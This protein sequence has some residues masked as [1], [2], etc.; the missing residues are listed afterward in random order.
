M[1]KR[2]RK[3]LAVMLTVLMLFSTA[4]VSISS[5]AMGRAPEED[6]LFCESE[7]TDPA[8]TSSEDFTEEISENGTEGMSEG[9]TEPISEMISEETTEETSE[10]TT[11][12]ASE[13]PETETDIEQIGLDYSV[14][15]SETT[16]VRVI[17]GQEGI[18][19]ENCEITAREVTAEEKDQIAQQI[20]QKLY[21]EDGQML[22]DICAYDIQIFDAE[23]T[24]IHQLDGTVQ[25][26]LSGISVPEGAQKA[27]VYHV[28][29]EDAEL[30][31]ALEDEAAV[32][33]TVTFETDHFSVYAVAH[34]MS[35]QEAVMPT[36]S[37]YEDSRSDYPYTGENV[38]VLDAIAQDL[39][40]TNSKE[41]KENRI[42]TYPGITEEIPSPQT[43]FQA[44]RIDVTVKDKKQHTIKH[45]D[46]NLTKKEATYAL[47]A[48]V[49]KLQTDAKG[50]ETPTFYC[51]MS[52]EASALAPWEDGD[53]LP[54]VINF[55]T[56]KP[57]PDGDEEQKFSYLVVYYA[58]QGRLGY[59]LGIIENAGEYPLRTVFGDENV[60]YHEQSG[61]VNADENSTTR[62]FVDMGAW[63]DRGESLRISNI[64]PIDTKEEY[65]FIAWFDKKQNKEAKDGRNY[66]QRLLSPGDTTSSCYNRVQG[67]IQTLDAIWANITATPKDK[68][69]DGTPITPTYEVKYTYDLNADYVE[70]INELGGMSHGE[71]TTKWY[72]DGKEVAANPTDAGTYTVVISTEVTAGTG[73]AAI[74]KTIST[75]TTVTIYPRTIDL[76]SASFTKV[77]DGTALTNG[78]AALLKNGTEGSEAKT[79][80]ADGEGANITFTG[81]QTEIGTSQNTFTYQLQS[82]TKAGNYT[83]TPTYGTLEVKPRYRVEYYYDG[84]M[85]TSESELHEKNG[86]DYYEVGDEVTLPAE[87]APAQ[88]VKDGKTYTRYKLQNQELTLGN[89]DSD[90]VIRVYY[91]SE[92]LTISAQK[93]WND[94]EDAQRI[95][96]EE[97]TLTLEKQNSESRTWETVG[98]PL[99][100]NESNHWSGTFAGE[101][102]SLE[103]GQLIHY[104][105][106]EPNLPE[107][108]TVEVSESGMAGFTVTNTLTKKDEP[109]APDP[110]NSNKEEEPEQEETETESETET[111]T[112]SEESETET[113]TAAEAVKTG[114]ST[115]PLVQFYLTL[116]CAAL[117]AAALTAK[118]RGK[119]TP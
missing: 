66:A 102:D 97:V 20:A 50:A 73:E 81:S 40:D 71:I 33:D 69:Y 100:L 27:A 83:I 60:R 5:I 117:A 89:K 11:E 37:G 98:S 55:Q 78:T 79:K 86:G 61:K 99:T 65:T 47:Q 30:V 70:Q 113:E 54:Q 114:D 62:K 41:K 10:E 57:D 36:A 35:V 93:V 74:T 22:L 56:E 104:R 23:G 111:E 13:E 44:T 16:A 95:R 9:T 88:K 118:L 108:Y 3:T 59:N 17:P 1:K 72:K 7:T 106:T 4:T 63:Y 119:K 29:G 64:V 34:S 38:A 25:V 28:N 32:S 77:Y 39:M 90:N 19:P 53:P 91:V 110:T 105:V 85:D 42:H 115:A 51:H 21:E 45:S 96:P 49:Y 75:T 43:I 87:Q 15:I 31:A 82:N 14:A 58:D 46:G 109:A 107:G 52:D 112:A 101:F 80:W 94:N 6:D 103:D 68:L 26:E 67:D 12:P 24:P 116:M 84:K 92:K 8:E 48:A 76:Q 2:N 18:L